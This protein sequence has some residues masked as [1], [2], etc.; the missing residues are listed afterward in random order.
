[1]RIA[2]VGYGRMGHLIDTIAKDRG[3]EVSSLIDPIFADS[4]EV[5]PGADAPGRY[6]NVSIE[7]LSGADVAIEFSLA[8]AVTENVKSYANA[9]VAAVIAT[10]GWQNDLETVTSLWKSVPH[11]LIHG[12]NFSIGANLFLR[13]A[14]YAA[15]LV[16]GI[17]EYDLL[18]HEIHH[19]RKADSP[20]GTSLM[21]ADRVLDAAPRKRLIKAGQIDRPIGREE[22]HISS[23]RGGYFP[24]THTLFLD[25]EADT[26]EIRHEARGRGGFALGAVMAAE[27]IAKKE[28]GV[29]S[30]ETFIT[31]LIA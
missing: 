19:G 14:E 31:D 7:A 8:D 22:L 10:T 6:S 11:G 24:G 26:I 2:I 4:G 1:M 28:G 29:Y 3:H 20:S 25:S 30:V 16:A 12:A 21:L 17:E 15:S 9:G 27:W 23:S 18:I 13:A 5:A